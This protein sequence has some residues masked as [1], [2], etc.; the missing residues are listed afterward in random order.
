MFVPQF[1][2]TSQSFRILPYSGMKRLDELPVRLL[3]DEIEAQLSER[4]RK[5]SFPCHFYEIIDQPSV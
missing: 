3:N 5:V 1:Y 4:G 2:T